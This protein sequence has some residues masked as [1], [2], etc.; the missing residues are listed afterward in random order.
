MKYK[1]I[2][3]N[4]LSRLNTHMENGFVC[5]SASRGNLS[6]KENKQRTQEL[7]KRAGNVSV[8]LLAN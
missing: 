3:K 5:I 7:K 2:E 8:W 6:A 4:T 1:L